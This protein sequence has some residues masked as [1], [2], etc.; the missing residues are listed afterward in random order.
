MFGGAKGEK[1]G[2][3]NL[4]EYDFDA[5]DEHE[6]VSLIAPE[7]AGVMRVSEDGSHVYFVSKAALAGP[8]ANEYGAT[9]AQ[10]AENLY[11]DDTVTHVV[12]FVAAMSPSDASEWAKQDS[13]EVAAT[14]EGRFFVFGSVAKDLTP[15]ASGGGR[16]FYRYDADETEEEESQHVP[17]LVRVTVGDR[18][19]DDGND[20]ANFLLAHRAYIDAV[21]P[22]SSLVSVTLGGAVFFE[23]EA[24]LTKQALNFTSIGVFQGREQ[25]A[26]N[27]YEYEDGQVYL[28]SQPDT[29]S[30]FRT[31][32]VVLVG[33]SP[34]GSDVYFKSDDALVGQAGEA[35]ENYIYD[36]RVDG[37]FPAPEVP[38]RLTECDGEACQTPAPSPS[39][40]GLPASATFSGPGN[41][42]ESLVVG[43]AGPKAPPVAKAGALAK[44]LRACRS[45][46][47][48]RR[49]VACE[50]AARAK[51]RGERRTAS[52]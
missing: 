8:T 42:A 30:T 27:V 26:V 50:R 21:D 46:H 24:G 16:Q 28:I 35:G 11:V 19:S 49:R 13:R 22:E 5:E 14:P 44:A 15:G 4:Y 10:G 52:R 23:S 41:L 37:G 36:A 2:T 51:Y 9:P 40:P 7:M 17:R 32:S 12:T 45:K 39:I 34:S 6:R 31:S 38:G 47:G 20:G 25:F 18:E 33:A 3:E 43:D 1:L 48:A 29:H